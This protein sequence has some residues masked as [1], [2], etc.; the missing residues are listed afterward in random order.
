MFQYHIWFLCLFVYWYF[1]S[2]SIMF[3]RN[4]INNLKFFFTCLLMY[5]TMIN[6]KFCTQVSCVLHYNC[7]Y[8]CISATWKFSQDMSSKTSGSWDEHE[9]R[10]IFNIQYHP[11][12]FSV[13]G[14]G[15]NRKWFNVLWRLNFRL[16]LPPLKIES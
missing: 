7:N 5:F 15:I 13:W 9:V 11:E 14:N 12:D 6:N 4:W 10:K 1:W 3:W 8:I 16:H 2:T